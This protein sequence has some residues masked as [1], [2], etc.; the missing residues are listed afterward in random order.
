MKYQHTKET[1]TIYNSM[2]KEYREISCDSDL[3]KTG[4]EYEDY[5]SSDF[6]FFLDCLRYNGRGVTESIRV[7]NWA[8]RHGCYVERTGD[9]WTVKL[10]KNEKEA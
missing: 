4:L 6:G 2:I 1:A 9:G 5:Q 3:E 10:K 8:K 7:A